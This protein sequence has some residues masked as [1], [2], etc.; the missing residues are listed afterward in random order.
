MKTTTKRRLTTFALLLFA[1]TALACGG[2]AYYA[3]S[4]LDPV[5][6]PLQFSLKAGSSLKSSAQQM[7]E[8]GMLKEPA[9]FVILG[10]LL[11]KA[12]SIKAGNYEVE[13]SQKATIP[14]MSSPSSR[15]GPSGGCARRSTS[16]PP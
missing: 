13:K 10:R 4:D 8:A 5:Q 1:C 9:L 3:Y 15:A 14:R 6:M 7:V 12:A 2:F 11:G 16:I